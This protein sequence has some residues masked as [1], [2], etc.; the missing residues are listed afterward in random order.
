MLNDPRIQALANITL[1][2]VHAIR[3]IYPVEGTPWP[4]AGESEADA[5]GPLLDLLPRFAACWWVPHNGGYRVITPASEDPRELQDLVCLLHQVFNHYQ[6]GRTGVFLNG[7]LDR[8]P[9]R[10]E[11]PGVPVI[12]KKLLD[13]LEYAARSLVAAQPDQDEAG[14][15][16]EFTDN[17]QSGT[18]Q[19]T[20]G[21]TMAADT[22]VPQKPPLRAKC[23]TA[24]GEARSKLI[25]ALTQHHKYSN[26]SCLNTEPIGNNQLANQAKVAPSTASN[27]FK[28]KFGGWEQYRALCLRSTTD[29]VAAL[30]LLNGEYPPL[31]LYGKAPP[32]EIE[33][34]AD[35]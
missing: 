10:W 16:A 5:V 17:D 2:L 8:R 6:W 23:S 35:E 18:A 1:K 31:L 12:S 14:Q 4:K 21:N 19:A 28:K 30:K 3:K 26:D 20:S 25:A 32:G 9:T 13:D 15:G 29:L 11:W 22:A 27:F 34:T 7:E 33:H 24:S